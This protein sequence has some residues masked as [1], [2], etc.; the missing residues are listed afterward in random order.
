QALRA[1]GHSR[2]VCYL[3]Y[4]DTIEPELTVSPAADVLV[5]FAPRERC[6][7]H[8]LDDPSCAMNRRYAAALERYA[9]LFEGRVRLF[10]YYGD[11]IL[12]CGCAVPLRS[13]IDADLTYYERLGLPGMTMLQFGSYSVWA[14]AL[15][16]LSFATRAFAAKDGVPDRLGARSA[17]EMYCARFGACAS[18]AH[19]LLDDVEAI[20]RPLVTYG[21]IRRPPRA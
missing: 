1:A 10:E 2:P 20:M 5:E 19:N 6:Y 4:H 18:Q 14:Y 3:A 11:A 12:F 9:E 17:L 15:N 16:F 21:D 13:V 8:P 7:G